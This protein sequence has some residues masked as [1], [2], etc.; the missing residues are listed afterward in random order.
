MEILQTAGFPTY[1][2]PEQAV[3]AFLHL[4]AYTRRTS[5]HELI[6]PAPTCQHTPHQPVPE[7]ALLQNKSGTLSEADSKAIFSAYGIPVVATLTANSRDEAIATAQMLGYPVVLKVRSP[8][9]SHKADVGGVRLNLNSAAA[10]GAAFDAIRESLATLR[11]EATFE[12]VTVQ[13]MVDRALGVEVIVGARRD[14]TFGPIALVGAGGAAVEVFGDRAIAL[15]PIN[16][17]K[18]VALLQSLRISPM[19]GAFRGRLA[20]DTDG[21]ANIVVAIGQLLQDLERVQEAEANPILVT[22]GSAIALDAR[23]VLRR[24]DN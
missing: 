21:L 13:R 12:G 14:P 9:V 20:L 16:H 19:L 11:P 24:A 4:S 22:P 15:A 5:R 8:S 18:A 3:D 7:E 17:G 2:T 23:V 6:E 10:V 1:E